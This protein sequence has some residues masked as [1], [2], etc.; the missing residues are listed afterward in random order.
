[1]SK[2]TILKKLKLNKTAKFNSKNQLN[3]TAK[4]NSKKE[5]EL[6]HYKEYADKLCLL[7]QLSFSLIKIHFSQFFCAILDENFQKSKKISQKR[8]FFLKMQ[9]SF[10]NCPCCNT[11]TTD[12]CLCVVKGANPCFAS[13]L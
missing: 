1:M 6:S 11:K 4:F 7:C 2:L 10:S 13:V 8:N 5:K 12:Y 3:K 9:K